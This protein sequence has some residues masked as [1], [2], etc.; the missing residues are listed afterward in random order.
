MNVHKEITC[1]VFQLVKL[2]VEQLKPHVFPL[3][4]PYVNL[5]NFSC[6]FGEGLCAVD[7][8]GTKKI[9][10]YCLMNDMNDESVCRYQCDHDSSCKGYDLSPDDR[11]VF[12]S[13]AICPSGFSKH[14]IGYVGEFI[15]DGYPLSRWSGCYKKI[16]G[17][18]RIY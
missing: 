18:F 10:E 5:S 6:N 11:C 13:T 3:G 16:S 1:D 17:M 4:S 15:P 2:S 14:S 12:Y 7:I 9:H 8:D